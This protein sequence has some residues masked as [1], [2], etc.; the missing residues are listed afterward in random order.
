LEMF[1][2]SL[3]SSSLNRL[4]SMLICQLKQLNIEY[5]N[6]KSRAQEGNNK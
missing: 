3:K 5:I 4:D 1:L 2:A 6:Y